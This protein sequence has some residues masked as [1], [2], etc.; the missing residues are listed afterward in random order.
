MEGLKGVM[1]KGAKQAAL[2]LIGTKFK[3]VMRED[4]TSQQVKGDNSGMLARTQ[5]ISPA[6]KYHGRDHGE[7][8]SPA[9]VCV[10]GT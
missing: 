8:H 9:R 6:S 10:G 5:A 7:H 4:Y 2:G 1:N 3:A